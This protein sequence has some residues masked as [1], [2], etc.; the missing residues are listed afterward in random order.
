MNFTVGTGIRNEIITEV[1]DPI[2]RINR[3]SPNEQDL[4][5]GAIITDIAD[6]MSFLILNSG[7]INKALMFFALSAG[8]VD[9]RIFLTIG[10]R[11]IRSIYFG[12]GKIILLISDCNK[13]Q[14]QYYLHLSK[15]N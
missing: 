5:D 15:C 13:C 12:K 1:F 8:P 3:S 10:N 7:V 14:Q 6:D 2:S 9:D 4:I 11:S